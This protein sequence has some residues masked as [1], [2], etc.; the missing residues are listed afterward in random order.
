MSHRSSQS[1]LVSRHPS[2][3][4]NGQTS[5]SIPQLRRCPAILGANTELKALIQS[6][7]VSA[8]V[9]L[10][11]RHRA[12]I[13][14]FV[15][16]LLS[17]CIQMSRNVNFATTSSSQI[18]FNLSL[19]CL[20]T[21]RSYSHQLLTSSYSTENTVRLH[22]KDQS[23]ASAIDYLMCTFTSARDTGKP[24]CQMRERPLRPSLGLETLDSRKV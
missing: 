13:F 9:T 23:V 1:P 7:S 12:P 21:I 6:E 8:A 16:V 5:R 19:I 2:P 15:M 20:P 14:Q 24:E 10:C 11:H 3:L 22:Y 4:K 18:L 17:S